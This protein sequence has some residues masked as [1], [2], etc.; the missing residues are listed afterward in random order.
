MRLFDG[1]KSVVND[2]TGIMKQSYTNKVNG[3][4]DEAISKG[5]KSPQEVQAFANKKLKNNSMAADDGRV[6][7]DKRKK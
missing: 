6:A 4:V 7:A 2:I 1:P 5:A 3:I